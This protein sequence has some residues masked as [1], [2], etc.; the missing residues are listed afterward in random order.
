LTPVDPA[1]FDIEINRIGVASM[2]LKILFLKT[3]RSTLLAVINL[4]APDLRQKTSPEV[5]ISLDSMEIVE[6]SSVDLSCSCIN[7]NEFLTSKK[8][9]STSVDIPMQTVNK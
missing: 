6:K 9:I 4:R 5:L 8:V 7:K 3:Y 1:W 2:F